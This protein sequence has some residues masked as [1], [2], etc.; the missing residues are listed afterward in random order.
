MLPALALAALFVK[1]AYARLQ[2]DR[3]SP[4]RMLRIGALFGLTAIA[5]QD[6]LHFSLLIPSNAFF[7]A[8][9]VGVVLRDAGDPARR[10]NEVAS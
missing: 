7:A 8:V 9:L 6:L 5:L 3:D 10:G 2:Q 1:S 4:H